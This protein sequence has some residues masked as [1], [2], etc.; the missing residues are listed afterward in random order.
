[1]VFRLK[2]VRRRKTTLSYGENVVFSSSKTSWTN[3]LRL[4]NWEKKK[5]SFAATQ[6][7]SSFNHNTSE[8]NKNCWILQK[9]CF[10]STIKLEVSS[11]LL[12][13]EVP[14]QQSSSS[15]EAS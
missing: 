13:E 14:L 8:K 15:L 12:E 2:F 4:S 1:M 6:V 7:F 11:W 9:K 10:C 5:K 3:Y